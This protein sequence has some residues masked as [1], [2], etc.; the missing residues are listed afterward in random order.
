M[1]NKTIVV[2]FTVMTVFAADLRAIPAF[3]R[4]YKLSCSICHAPF[5]KLKEYGEEFAGNG[6]ILKE[7]EK[8]RDYISAGDD[9]LWLNRTLPLAVRFDAYGIFDEGSD[10]KTDLQSPWGLKLLSGGTLYRN[11]GYYFY[12]FMSERGEVAGIEDAY[13]H[14]NA[15]FGTPL[16]IMVGQFQTSDPLMKRELRL[17]YEDYII[18][19]VNPGLSRTDLTY[20]RGLM[21][22]YGLD[23]TGTE[24]VFQLVNG[25]GKPEADDKG[26]F[27]Q[28]G[29]K[30]MGFRI[31]QDVLGWFSIGGYV[32]RG[33]EK[34]EDGIRNS[35]TCWGPDITAN[36]GPV[37]LTAQVLEREDSDAQFDRGATLKTRGTVIEAVYSPKLDRSRIVLTGLY[38]HVDSDLRSLQYETLTFSST[39]L[40]ARNL[41]LIFEG[42]R[43]LE[44]QKNRFVLGLISGF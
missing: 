16:D 18:Y 7:E 23:R 17:T 15:V 8:A 35:L 12:F 1:N 26:K 13:I 9:L 42:T 44:Q 27:D 11:I 25:N 10:V 5:P 20:D 36:A 31:R 34:N 28:D 14:F 41:R 2:F 39:T 30:N 24:F 19:K 32:Y 33:R 29:Y 37:E 3:A 38:N 40:I 21:L 6:M 22:V 4:R 43:D